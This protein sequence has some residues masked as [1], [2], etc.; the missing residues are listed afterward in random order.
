MYENF[1]GS[2]PENTEGCQNIAGRLSIKP[3]DCIPFGDDNKGLKN[4]KIR[5]EVF[6]VQYYLY[7]N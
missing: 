4:K 1:D 2:S 6:E 7:F 5:E 3:E